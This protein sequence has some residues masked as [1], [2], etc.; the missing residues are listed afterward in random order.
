MYIKTDIKK[1]YLT[2]IAVFYVV[3]VI[4]ITVIIFNISYNFIVGLKC[5]TCTVQA[6]SVDQR[7]VT[8]PGSVE[9]GSAVTNCD[10]DYCVAKRVEFKVCSSAV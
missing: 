7:C 4:F 2:F 1:I 5:Y 6:G 10:K 9:T 3:L 8:S